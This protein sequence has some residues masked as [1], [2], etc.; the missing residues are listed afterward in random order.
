MTQKPIGPRISE[1]A[2]DFYTQ[3]F[4][5]SNAGARYVLESFP[6]IY[7]ATLSREIKGV[8]SEP[9]LCL[10]LD[11]MNATLLTPE[12][13]GMTLDANVQDGIALD[14]LDEKWELAGNEMIEKMEGLSLFQRNVLEIWCRL[15]WESGEYEK[16]DGLQN[17]CKSLKSE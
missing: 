5:N 12:T 6:Q 8:F 13:A 14:G 7:R 2:F 3:T 16:D 11:A 1:S 10:M 9:E 17:W 15:F 4:D